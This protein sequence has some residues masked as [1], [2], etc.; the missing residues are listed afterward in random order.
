MLDLRTKKAVTK[1]SKVVSSFG[2]RV[3]EVG[4]GVRDALL[5]VPSKDVDLLVTGVPVDDLVKGL[6]GKVDL[7]GASFGVL[8]VTLEGVTLDV[9]LPRSEFST[10]EGHRDFKVESDHSLP[11]EADL[12]RRDFTMNAVAVDLVSGE[13]VDPFGGRSDVEARLVRAVGD[14]L[15]RFKEDPLRVL[16]ALRFV[17]KLGFDVESKTFGAMRECAPLVA[18]VS[19]E[20]VAGELTGLLSASDASHVGKALRFLRDSGVLEAVLPEFTDAI[21]FDQRSPYHDRTVDE[22]TFDT[23][24]HTVSRGASLE[25]RLAA[26]LHDI[27][28]PEMF[29]VGDDGVGHFYRHEDRGAEVAQSVLLRLRMASKVVGRVTLLVAEHP[30]PTP[31]V[32]KKA[33]RR[34]VARMGEAT[35]DA[36]MLR[37]AD[38]AAHAGSSAEKARALMDEVREAVKSL[39]VVGFDHK[40]LALRGDEIMELFGVSGREVGHLKEMATR[41]VVDGLVPN[42]KGCVRR[43]LLW[44]RASCG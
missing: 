3:F 39:D 28:K 34:F 44:M 43:Y 23:V 12:S 2:G 21:G 33:L 8:K 27:A 36:L 20:R 32:G 5:G 7:V 1:V 37:E 13:V 17:A 26:L 18:T 35:E 4:G 24:E 22:H 25:V 9:A 19:P 30:K 11:V 42:E 38:L 40:Q 15:E 29:S 10:G 16:R 41:A 6:P 14:P 31:P